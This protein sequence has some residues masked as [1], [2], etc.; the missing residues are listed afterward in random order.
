M[1]K[2]IAI[3]TVAVIFTGT[4][5]ADNVYLKNGQVYTDCV[6][7]TLPNG[8]VEITLKG[9]KM[10]L[11]QTEIA[12]IEKEKVNEEDLKAGEPEL[13]A[14]LKAWEAAKGKKEE[15]GTE[16]KPDETAQQVQQLVGLFKDPDTTVRDQAV[17]SLVAMG[18][19]ATPHLLKYL[20]DSDPAIRLHTS[21]V[22]AQTKPKDAVRQLLET[23]YAGSP[24]QGRAPY[25]MVEYLMNIN[26]ALVGVT[27][28]NF[29]YI[30]NIDTQFE[31]VD[32]FVEWY[33]ANVTTLPAQ[34]GDPKKK[35]GEEDK[36]YE[37]RVAKARQLKLA[38]R[39]FEAP[40]AVP[41]TPETPQPQPEEGPPVTPPVAPP[42]EG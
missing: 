35:E 33:K 5:S 1:L 24:P 3:L 10:V 41:E 14:V 13:S 15:A 36:A 29:Y 40:G 8:N 30:P 34:I 23:L 32:K 2:R 22:L 26:T 11:P 31:A 12:Y 27:G 7:K 21:A 19:K 18:S 6:A 37:E 42:A 4:A 9:G 28:Q 38:R 25:Y 39:S 16:T 17:Q 20:E